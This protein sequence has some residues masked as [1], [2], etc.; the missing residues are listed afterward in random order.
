[1]HVQLF[2]PIKL[3]IN[4]LTIR[5]EMSL[6]SGRAHP[7][8]SKKISECLQMELLDVEV[9]QFKDGEIQAYY[10]DTI[11]G[12]FVF[13]I[14]PTCAPSDNLIELLILIDAAKRA[15]AQKIIAVIPYFGYARQ[16]RK[17]KPRTSIGAKLMAN[18]LSAAGVNRIITLDL[19]ADQIQGFFEIPVDHLYASN[20]FVPYIKNLKLNNLCIV[21]PDTGGTKRASTY[22]NALGCDLA[23][24][25][26]Q[27]ETQNEVASLQIIGEVAGKNCI[28]VDDMIDTGGTLC[29]AAQALKEAGALSVRAMCVHGLLSGNGIEN[30]EASVIDKLILTDSIPLKRECSKIEIVSIAPL[31]AEVITSVMK[32]TSITSHFLFK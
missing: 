32:K 20:V 19:H 4:M 30:I 24:G 18:L 31:F 16:D 12:K 6:V 8:L 25:F 1:M 28:I 3:K 17:D 9:K 23:I 26:K 2:K 10:I 27:R 13:I 11:R 21:S 29:K 7:E 14:Q 22:A 5:E 15:S